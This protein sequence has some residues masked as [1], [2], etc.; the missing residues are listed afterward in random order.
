MSHIVTKTIA[1][2]FVGCNLLMLNDI[3][4]DLVRVMQ[5]YGLLQVRG[6]YVIIWVDIR[7]AK[8]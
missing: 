8:Q 3:E 2:A 6:D 5:N 4:V 1:K 7:S